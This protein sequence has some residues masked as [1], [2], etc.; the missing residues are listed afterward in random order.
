MFANMNWGDPIATAQCPAG[1]PSATNIDANSIKTGLGA[2]GNEIKVEVMS[3]QGR[4]KGCRTVGLE[5][6]RTGCTVF[7]SFAGR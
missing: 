4:G 6:S 2:Q 1:K 7:E 3:G 5:R